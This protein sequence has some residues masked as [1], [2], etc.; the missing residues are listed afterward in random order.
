MAILRR[1]ALVVIKT[2]H[3]LRDI[4]SVRDA[5]EALAG[6]WP[7]EGR[8][9]TYRAA[10]RLCLAAFEGNATA[11]S[12]RNAFIRAAVDAGIIVRTV[13]LKEGPGG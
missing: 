11:D 6:D 4:T 3:G 12:A 5:A 9:M 7:K 2:S 1:F 13:E 8:G 10:V